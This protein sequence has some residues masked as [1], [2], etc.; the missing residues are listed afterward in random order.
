MITT[1]KNSTSAVILIAIVGLGAIVGYFYYSQALQ[2]QVQPFASFEIPANDNLIKFKDFNLDFGPFDDLQFKV[3]RV[4][5]E[6]PVNPGAAG[7]SD[8]FAPF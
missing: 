3:L 4:F 1:N 6:S 8:I 2:D 7:K 5:G